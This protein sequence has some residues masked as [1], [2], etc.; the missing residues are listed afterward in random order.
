MSDS[1]GDRTRSADPLDSRESEASCES[2]TQFDSGTLRLL[3]ASLNRIGEGLR[4]LEEVARF[5]LDDA[6]TTGALKALRHDLTAVEQALPRISRLAARDTAADVGTT[7]TTESESRRIDHRD[8]IAAAA[9]RV[10]QSLRVVEEQFKR[11]DAT[12]A[13]Q[14]ES[15]RYRFYDVSAELELS[16]QRVDRRRR[17]NE[18]AIYLLMTAGESSEEFEQQLRRV[19]A[20]GVDMVQLRDRTVDDRTLLERCR[21]AQAIATDEGTSV[22]IVNDRADIAA[23]ADADGVHVGQEELPTDDVRKIVGHGKLIG[24]STHDLDQVI[25][26]SGQPIDYIG[27]G[28]IFPSTTKAFDQYTGPE[29]LAAVPT[30]FDKPAFAIGGVDGSNVSRVA[31]TG[32]CRVAVSGVLNR[33]L[34]DAEE[35]RSETQALRQVLCGRR[36]DA[37]PRH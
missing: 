17:L 10:Q 14:V 27:C 11:F 26:A 30:H 9:S 2:G 18:S 19:F 21:I 36:Q 32:M 23:A 4:T 7:I 22:R 3:D 25:D 28:P 35:L 5:I 6:P 12:S 1:P 34:A 13:A 24:L 8:I 16:L 29:W 33:H 20:A 37:A 31:S 15:I